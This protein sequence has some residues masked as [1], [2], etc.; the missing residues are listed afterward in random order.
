MSRILR[1]EI[2]YLLNEIAQSLDISDTL[3]EDAERKYRAVGSWLGEG[4]SQLAKFTPE[5]Y[6][7]GSFLLGTVIKPLSD[8][9]EYDIDLVF[10]MLIL[11]DQISQ[12]S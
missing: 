1:P 6:P 2:G 11:K 9:D 3:F 7:Q 12:K 10:R 8:E 4:D 5:I